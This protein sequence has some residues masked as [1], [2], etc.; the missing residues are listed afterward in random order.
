METGASDCLY[1]EVLRFSSSAFDVQ[2]TA[3]NV[4]DET[5]SNDAEYLDNRSLN[6]GLQLL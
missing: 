3:A 2:P 1:P 4:A 6:E 5:A